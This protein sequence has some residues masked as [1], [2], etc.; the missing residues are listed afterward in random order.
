M[1]YE[2]D[3]TGHFSMSDAALSDEIHAQ[4][5]VKDIV[6]CLERNYRTRSTAIARL[7]KI[8]PSTICY[9]AGLRDLL[10]ALSDDEITVQEILIHYCPDYLAWDEAIREARN[11]G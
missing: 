5:V 11:V 4:M 2:R 9:D 6:M 1:S 10:S 3:D 8:I 7:K